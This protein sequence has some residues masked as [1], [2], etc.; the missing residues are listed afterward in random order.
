MTT[1][2]TATA[3]TLQDIIDLHEKMRGA[4]FYTPP[5]NATGRRSYERKNSMTT[6]FEYAGQRIEIVQDTQC[7]CKNVYYKMSINIDGR[8]TNKDIRFVKKMLKSL[9][10]AA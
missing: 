4:Y 1:T 10:I 3:R 7:S 2:A 8:G 9:E 6:E 5:G